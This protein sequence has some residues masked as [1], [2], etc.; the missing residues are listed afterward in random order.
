MKSADPGLG[1]RFHVDPSAVPGSARSASC[2]SSSDQAA[3]LRGDGKAIGGRDE[4]FE[5]YRM[6]H[7]RRR[8]NREDVHAHI[9]HQQQ[10]SHGQ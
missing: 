9:L 8:R 5:V 3:S 7:R 10:F 1:L 6:R 2:L 4:S